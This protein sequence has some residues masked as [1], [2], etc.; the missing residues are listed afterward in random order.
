MQGEVAAPERKSFGKLMLGEALCGLAAAGSVAPAIAI[1]DQSIFSNASGRERMLA[2]VLRQTGIMLRQ[3]LT[4]FRQPAVL[5]IYA[6]YGSTYVV[7]NCGEVGALAQKTLLLRFLLKISSPVATIDA[8]QTPAAGRICGAAKVSYDFGYQRR[9][10]D[11]QRCASLARSASSL[12]CWQ[13]VLLPTSLR[14]SAKHLAPCREWLL[15]CLR[16]ATP[17]LSVRGGACV[18]RSERL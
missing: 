4:F 10:L 14:R 7:A 18:C 5:W 3:P 9:C 6:V 11:C 8:V 13:I 17:S 16:C 2:C 15:A 1:V 12:F